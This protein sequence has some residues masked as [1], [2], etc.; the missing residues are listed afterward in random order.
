MARIRTIKPA[1]FLDEDLGTIKRDARLL[2][3]G[4]WNH[5]DDRG[6]FE[7][8]PGKIK[9]EIFPY[10]ADVNKDTVIKWLEMLKGLGNIVYFEEKGK[11]YGYIPTFSDHQ[12]VDKPSTNQY[13]TESLPTVSERSP[14]ALESS[15]PKSKVKVKEEDGKKVYGIG[16]NVKLTD[17]EYHK[18]VEIFGVAGTT[19][20]ID[21]LSTYIGS[22]GDKYKSH[23]FTIL[24][25][26][27]REVKEGKNG[28]S[29]TAQPDN[30]TGRTQGYSSEE[31]KRS[32]AK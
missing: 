14:N 4:L 25:W 26:N 11:P 17:D 28:N 9:V 15:P 12:K 18:L 13:L 1:F 7:Y 31:Y 6:V 23:Y 29:R 3:I 21:N 8:R 16:K 19:P 32:L 2:Y 20:R 5:S 22:H 27:S 10:D 30:P 24:N